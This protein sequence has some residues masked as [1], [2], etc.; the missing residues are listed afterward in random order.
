MH[1]FVKLL[2]RWISGFTDTFLHP[3][4]DIYSQGMGE[5]MGSV[6]FDIILI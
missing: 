4:Q 1:V 3:P 2:L 6:R 5:C